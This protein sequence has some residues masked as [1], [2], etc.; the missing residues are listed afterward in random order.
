MNLYLLDIC[1]Y[2]DEV[3]IRYS[4]SGKNVSE[5]NIGIQCPF[6][7]DPSDHLGIHLE[8]KTINCWRCGA[9]GTAIKLIMKLERIGFEQA[10]EKI[11][12]L[13]SHRKDLT[14]NRTRFDS[15]RRTG[16]STLTLPKESQSVLLDKHRNFLI[17]RRFDPDHIFSKYDLRCVEHSVD[18]QFRLI[19]PIKR[20]GRAVAWTGRDV[21]GQ[22]PVPYLNAPKE[23]CVVP[24]KETLYNL[25]SVRDTAIVVE[26]PLDVWRIGDGAVC[27]YGTKYTKQQI[28]LLSSLRR[29]FVLFDSDA[30]NLAKNFGTDLSLFVPQTEVIELDSGDPADMAPSDVQQLRKMVFGSIF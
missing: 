12:S 11:A 23:Q 25:D 13:T 15:E 14:Q 2:L 6:C 29:V 26:G 18:W 21:T 27:T 3:G 4:H 24:V 28:L 30:K 19:I 16:I 7:D 8:N 9:R 10:L 17:K 20:H 22:A 1:K 5:G